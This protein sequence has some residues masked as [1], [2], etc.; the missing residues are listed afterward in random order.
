MYGKLFD[1]M[2]QGT[3]AED[4]RAL[5]TF[6]QMII[7]CDQDGIIDVTPRHIT[8]IT[9]IP[10]EVIE[11]GI[12][13]LE[14]PDPRS[15]TP[16]ENGKRIIRLDDHRDWGWYI[17]NHELYK[18][19][20]DSHEVREQNRERKRRQRE[21]ERNGEESQSVTD[22]TRC[23]TKSRHIDID[24]D[25]KTVCESAKPKRT[26]TLKSRHEKIIDMY[27]EICPGRPG[28]VKSLWPGSASARNLDARLNQDERFQTQEFWQAFF[29]T[30]AASDWWMGRDE[31]WP[32]G[33]N[34]HWLVK[35]DNFR[36]VVEAGMS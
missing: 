36:K 28:V 3:L 21:R 6:Q 2:Y 20:V 33:A 27:A 35:R 19:L 34:L 12:S 24:I 18:K 11:A 16:D 17:V 14:Q 29:E 32:K 26:Q 9:N 22:V 13:L 5:V 10:I 4:W 25:K 23:H 8:A 15:R 31:K 30:V 1:S 7:M